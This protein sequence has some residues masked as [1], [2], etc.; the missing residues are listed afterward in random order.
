MTD[1]HPNAGR[2]VPV[3]LEEIRALHAE[4]GAEHSDARG[5]DDLADELRGFRR[6]FPDFAGSEEHAMTALLVERSRVRE[7]ATLVADQDRTSGNRA[8]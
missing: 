4:R 8:G 7:A 3:E 1:P 2:E 6:D 5:L